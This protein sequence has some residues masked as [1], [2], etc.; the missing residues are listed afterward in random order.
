VGIGG[1]ASIGLAFLNLP[2]GDKERMLNL[3]DFGA[4]G[5]GEDARMDLRRAGVGEPG[6]EIDLIW[7]GAGALLRMVGMG[8]DLIDVRIVR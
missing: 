4:S 7:A 2:M 1:A 6:G 5:V 3:D 8:P